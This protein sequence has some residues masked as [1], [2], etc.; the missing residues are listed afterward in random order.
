MLDC[1]ENAECVMTRYGAPQCA[2]AQGYRGNGTDCEILPSD[3]EI[4]GESRP[5]QIRYK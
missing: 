2:C 3:I 4:S 1:D 5:N